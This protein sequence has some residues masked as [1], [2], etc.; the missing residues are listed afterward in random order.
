MG[1]SREDLEAFFARCQSAMVSR[2]SRV[3]AAR[4]PYN[5]MG[6]Y[7]GLKK[8][9]IH[10]DP[11]PDSLPLISKPSTLNLTL[12]YHNLFSVGPNDKP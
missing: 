10:Q 9:K 12:D 5:P 11:K 3:W 6:A 2:V 4:G 1:S 8:N 7:K